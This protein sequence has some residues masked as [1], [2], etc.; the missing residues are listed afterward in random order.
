[1]FDVSNLENHSDTYQKKMRKSFVY[2]K[3]RHHIHSILLNSPQ[4]E[5]K[6]MLTHMIMKKNVKKLWEL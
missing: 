5:Q 4:S 6:H 3:Q 2:S 1:M